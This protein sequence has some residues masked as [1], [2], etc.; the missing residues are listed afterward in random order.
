MILDTSGLLAA[1]DSD[2]RSH[3]AARRAIEADGGPFILSPF[4]LAELDYLL[5]TRVGRGAQLALLDE[6]GRGA[7]RLERFTA[8]DVA[9][10]TEVLRR[11]ED[12]DLGLTDASNVVLSRRHGVSDILTLDE[13]HFRV[14]SAAENR[15]FRLLPADL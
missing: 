5:A 13:R 10:A 1:I 9:R 14:L 2:Q 3:A 12:L 7:Y 6:V 15:P 8:T 4:V 11:Y